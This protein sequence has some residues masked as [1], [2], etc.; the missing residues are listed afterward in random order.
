MDAT[1]LR[2]NFLYHMDYA[3]VGV[4]FDGVFIKYFLWSNEALSWLKEHG[5]IKCRHGNWYP[6]DSSIKKITIESVHKD[7]NL[8]C[9]TF[10]SW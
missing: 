5:H 10:E 4:W 1:E 9:Y 2:N 7:V 3:D 8:F 6:A